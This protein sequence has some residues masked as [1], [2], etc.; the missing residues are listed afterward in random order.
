MITVHTDVVGSLLRPPPLLKAREEFAAGSITPAECKAIED[1]AVDS[2]VKLQEDA[3]LDVVT[4][5]EMR[6]LSFQSALTD[7]VEGF[8]D[9]PLEAFLWGDW[10]SEVHGE[11]SIARPPELGVT[12]R[13]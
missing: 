7:A 3:G 6:R 9:V 10:H 2:A 1:A 12:T 5:G 8:G 13:L 11:M 4:D